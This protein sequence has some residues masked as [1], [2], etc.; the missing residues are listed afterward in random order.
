MKNDSPTFEITMHQKKLNRK[1]QISAGILAK[2]YKR[3]QKIQ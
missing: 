2:H 3:M 1:I